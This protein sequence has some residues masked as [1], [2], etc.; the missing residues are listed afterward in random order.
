MN[1]VTTVILALLLF[2]LLIFVHEFGHFIAARIFGVTVREFAIGMGP[3]IIKHTSK[4]SGVCYALKLFPIGGSV[5]MV[6][7]DEAADDPGAFNKKEP[8]KRLIILISGAAMNLL[9]GFL[10]MTVLVLF[11]K[12]LYSAKI[13]R[14]H[15][16]NAQTYASGLQ[17]GDDIVRVDGKYVHTKADL[18]YTVQRYGAEPLDITVIRNGERVKV[19]NVIF[20]LTAVGGIDFDCAVDQKTVGAVIKHSFS[21]SRTA[22]RIIWDT[23]YDLITGRLGISALSGPVGTTTAIGQVAKQGSL[24][25]LYFCGF[26]TLNLG[27]VNLLPFPGLDGGRS[28]FVLIEMI[29][30]KP[31]KPEYEGYVHFAGL[32]L[33]MI[34]M[35]VVTVQDFARLFVK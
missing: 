31:I 18:V 16:E 9:L 14:F 21:Q 15:S 4:K 1:I 26:I 6:G 10:I 22:I 32:I 29:R 19:E 3:R 11:A 7:E 5:S 25:L 35:L 12:G 13:T 20:P 8:W 17:I 2:S 27:I 33:L 34:L 24:N 30:G 23:L 28:V